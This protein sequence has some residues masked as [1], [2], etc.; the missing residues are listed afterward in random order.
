VDWLLEE[1]PWPDPNYFAAAPTYGQAKRVFWN[2]LKNMIPKQWIRKKSESELYINTIWGST[3][4]V[5]GMDKP[6]RIEGS[7]WDGGILD[8]FGNMKAMTWDEN[9]RPALADRRGWCW[10]IGVPEGRNHYY[11]KWLHAISGKDPEWEG[12]TW[13]SSTVLPPDEIESARRVYD[14][15]T[16]RQEYE[17]SF[18]A[19]EGVVYYNFSRKNVNPVKYNPNQMLCLRFD[20]NQTPMSCTAAQIYKESYGT[21]ALDHVK[22]LREW[23]INNSNTPEMCQAILADFPDHQKGAVIY[24]DAF[25]DRGTVGKTDY[26]TIEEILGDRA[27]WKLWKRVPNSN[28]SVIDRINSTNSMMCSID[29]HIRTTV[30]PSCKHL[31][32]DFERVTFK[33]GTRVINKDDPKYTHWSDGHGYHIHREYPIRK[34]KRMIA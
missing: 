11:D 21:K 14:E 9:V 23:S 5:F 2:D 8:E 15:R 13:F 32:K 6:E 29:G 1:K 26:D 24:G 34:F 16:F 27:G 28:P 22:V 4:Y 10:L 12:F 19:Y 17:G 7:P 33:E 18:E 30:D 31:I 3:L 25:G 20:F